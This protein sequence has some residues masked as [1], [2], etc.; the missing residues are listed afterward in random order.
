MGPCPDAAISDD[1]RWLYDNVHL[2]ISELDEC[3]RNLQAPAEDFLMSALRAARL[4]RG[5]RPWPRHFWPQ[6]HTSLVQKAFT[7][8]L[9]AFQQQTVLKMK[10][11]WALVPVLKL[12]LLEQIAVRGAQANRESCGILRCWRL[13]AQSSRCQSGLLERRARAA[14]SVRSTFCARIRR[15]PMPGWTLTAVISIETSSW[16]SPSTPISLRWRLPPRC[17][18]SRGRP[19]NGR[20]PIRASAA[21]VFARWLLSSCRRNHLTASE[22][23]LHAFVVPANIVSPP[24]VSR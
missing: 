13:C 18:R 20:R 21:A 15:A 5:W 24:P 4:F 2:V 8:Y 10:E 1:S 14:D 17:S 16:K 19:S 23:G 7:S 11:L 22:G 6:P 9:E 3:G 12:V